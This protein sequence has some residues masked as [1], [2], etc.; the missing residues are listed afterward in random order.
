[1][2]DIPGIMETGVRGIALS[3]P[4]SVPM[5]PYRRCTRYWPSDKRI[6][7]TL[8]ATIYKEYGKTDYC[9]ARI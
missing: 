7:D 3:A 6:K 8:N 9:R 5:I 4:C 1:M 2:R